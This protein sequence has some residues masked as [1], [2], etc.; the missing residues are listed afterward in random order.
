MPP[1]QTQ[2]FEGD[3]GHYN[4]WKEFI[5][6]DECQEALKVQH[7]EEFDQMADEC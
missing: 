1:W 6:T 2:S 3:E 7:R 5:K 4:F